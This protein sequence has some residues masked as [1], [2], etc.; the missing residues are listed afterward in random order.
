MVEYLGEEEADMIRFILRELN[1]KIDPHTLLEQL[2]DVF[3]EVAEEFVMKLW[4]M[5]IF[6]QLENLN[7]RSQ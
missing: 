1:N 2:V 7:I 6:F 4:K 3:D 5:L